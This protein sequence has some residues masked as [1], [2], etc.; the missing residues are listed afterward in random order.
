VKAAESLL[1]AKWSKFSSTSKK[2]PD[3]DT[4]NSSSPSSS[5]ADKPCN[6][7]A[8]LPDLEDIAVTLYPGITKK[9]EV[10]QDGNVSHL[11]LILFTPFNPHQKKN[12]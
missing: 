6:I 12:P 2:M 3:P 4:A 11:L 9:K 10:K 5:S 8:P 7:C 1:K